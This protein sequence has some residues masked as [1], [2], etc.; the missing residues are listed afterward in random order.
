[1][2]AYFADVWIITYNS[3]EWRQYSWL[4]AFVFT[5]LNLMGIL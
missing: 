3:T 5:A 1:M 2:K 4:D